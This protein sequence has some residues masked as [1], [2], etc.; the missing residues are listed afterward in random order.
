MEE[1]KEQDVRNELATM[2]VE[3]ADEASLRVRQVTK[4]AEVDEVVVQA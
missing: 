3:R 2:R 4:V 1:L